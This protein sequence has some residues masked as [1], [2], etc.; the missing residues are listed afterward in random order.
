MHVRNAATLSEAVLG[1]P[2]EVLLRLLSLALLLGFG[3]LFRNSLRKNRRLTADLTRALDEASLARQRSDGV[4]AAIGDGVS[5]QGTDFRIL[6]QNAAHRELVQGDFVGR[7]CYQ[8]YDHQEQVCNNC[9]VA[10]TFA[11]GGIHRLEKRLEGKEGLSHIEILSS[12]LRNAAGEI[13]AGIEVV[14]D[15][16]LSKAATEEATLRSRFLQ[17]LID[18]IPNPLFYK[19]SAGRYQGCNQAFL[20]LHGLTR[21]AVVGRQVEDLAPPEL[22]AHYRQQDDALF[23]SGGIQ[24]YEEQVCCGDGQVRDFVFS[25]AT[26]GPEKGPPAGLVGVM[27]DLT[28]RKQT[29]REIRQLNLELQRQA[30][31]LAA[32]NRE[33]EAFGY[34]L[35]HDLRNPLSRVSLAAEILEE[36]AFSQLDETGQYCLVRI[37]E[38]C[39]SM[40][41]LSDALLRLSRLTLSELKREEVDLAA[42]AR[43]IFKGLTQEE[44]GRQSR[45]IAPANLIV[46]GDP[47]MLG[48]LLENLIG[49]AWKYTRDEELARIELGRRERE[50]GPVYFLCDNG[51]GFDMAQAGDLFQPFRRLHSQEQYPGAGIGLATVKRVVERHGGQVWAESAPGNGS[52]FFFSLLPPAG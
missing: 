6:Y 26:Y 37:R 44:T 49:N 16:S 38:G 21:E 1:E 31:E 25:K 48:V 41:M 13:V 10:R 34:S 47:Q 46:E 22:A 5:I 14:R 9:P 23:A 29:E 36:R 24:S 40:T 45:F 50:D 43:R 52:C 27:V 4:L 33:L 39:D 15:I 11:D 30:A 7:F 17:R 8:A 3:W 51:T 19:D 18:T 28:A 2:H 35:S 42:V 20:D 32:S 12:P